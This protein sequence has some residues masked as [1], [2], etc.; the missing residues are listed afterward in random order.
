MRAFER[1]PAPDGL[2]VNRV[3]YEFLR[4]VPIGE[5]SVSAEV[6]KPGKRARLLEAAI[7]GSDGAELVRARALQ[8]QPA[9]PGVPRTPDLRPPAGPSNGHAL[10]F[11]P[12]YRPMFVS[13][14]V[15]IRLI[16]GGFY[17]VGPA[18]GWFRLQVPLVAGE[19]PSAL[20]R[21]AAAGDFG[22]G[23]SAALPW[24]GYT[25]INPDLTLYIDR[26]PVGEWI[27]LDARTILAAGG[28]GTAES[29]LYDER[30]RIGRAM[31]AL[32]V[33]PR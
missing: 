1:L 7:T 4:P 31:Q 17:D 22:N 32:V 19:E 2:I 3:T 5:L 9:D 27:C 30:G 16:A 13:D 23:I 25:F 12:P 29:V 28:I 33:R 24:D 10:D 15:D 20:Q 11:R 14:A 21:L 18:T 8:V 6:V 26:E